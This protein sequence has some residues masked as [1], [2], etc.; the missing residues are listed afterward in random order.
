LLRVMIVR[1]SLTND[2]SSH[3]NVWSPYHKRSLSCCT[4]CQKVHPTPLACVSDRIPNNQNM[5]NDRLTLN[6][7]QMFELCLTNI[8][9]WPDQLILIHSDFFSYKYPNPHPF[10]LISAHFFNVILEGESVSVL[11]RENELSWFLIF[12][13][14]NIPNL[15]RCL[16]CWYVV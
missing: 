5:P 4:M 14:G 6:S 11:E 3:R 7:A 2:R 16:S 12:K 13:G 15:N 8:H 1:S 9:Q 10:H